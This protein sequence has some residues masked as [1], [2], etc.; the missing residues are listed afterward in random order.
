MG[1]IFYENTTILP[2]S[3]GFHAWFGKARRRAEFGLKF[4]G[5][6][7]ILSLELLRSKLWDSSL[8]TGTVGMESALVEMGLMQRNF[9]GLCGVE[10]SKIW[11]I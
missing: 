1:I 11:D 3:D 4:L 9:R 8:V 10:R 6:V 2:A 7:S 5:L